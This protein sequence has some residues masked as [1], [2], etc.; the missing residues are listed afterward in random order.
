M[1]RNN[2]NH[3]SDKIRDNKNIELNNKRFKINILIHIYNVKFWGYCNLKKNKNKNSKKANNK[4]S[5]N[6]RCIF[7]CLQL[8]I[9]KNVKTKK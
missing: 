1:R 4:C 6:T 9:Q 2:T 3:K 7:E 8:I 5:E